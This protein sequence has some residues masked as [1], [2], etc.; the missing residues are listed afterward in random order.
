MNFTRQPESDILITSPMKD[1]LCSR[2]AEPSE[3]I[4]H[5]EKVISLDQ[6][7]VRLHLVTMRRTFLL[8]I[9][10]DDDSKLED[11]DP[12]RSGFSGSN[13]ALDGLS[14]A[15]GDQ[16]THITS[17]GNL[18]ES[19]SLASRLSKSVNRNRPVYIANNFIYPTRYTNEHGQLASQLYMKIFQFVRSNYKPEANPS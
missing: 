15:I 14:L 5:F 2:A 11:A 10:N 6:M 13:H 9:G 8:Q 4:K 18:L 17:S 3:V 19:A 12:I 1:T 7:K 16:A